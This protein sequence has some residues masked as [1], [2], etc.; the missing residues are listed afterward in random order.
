ME[1][2]R[3]CWKLRGLGTTTILSDSMPCVLR[4]AVPLIL[5]SGMG[6]GSAAELG[7]PVGQSCTVQFRR[8]ALGVGGGTPVP[9]TSDSF[10][11]AATSL[12]GTLERAD[13]HWLVLRVGD[14]Q[15]WIAREVVLL[16]QYDA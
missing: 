9:P 15:Q 14:K 6:C 4:V 2:V 12:R 8:D 11:G 1:G 16:I 10:N 5:L 13:E 7:L 3:R